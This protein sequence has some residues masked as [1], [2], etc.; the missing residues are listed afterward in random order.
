MVK[1]ALRIL[2]RMCESPAYPCYVYYV[3][4]E[5]SVRGMCIAL[6]SNKQTL[7]SSTFGFAAV[8]TACKA[9]AKCANKQPYASLIALLL[10]ADVDIQLATLTLINTLT[11]YQFL[12]VHAIVFLIL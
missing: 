10:V 9:A 6:P 1:S 7:T 12:I 2:C 4:R 11:R 5:L 3:S 8:S